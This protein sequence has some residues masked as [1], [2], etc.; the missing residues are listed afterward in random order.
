[1][2][3]LFALHERLTQD[4]QTAISGVELLRGRICVT[5]AGKAWLADHAHYQRVYRRINGRCFRGS[6]PADH[7]LNQRFGLVLEEE[8]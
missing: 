4:S 2:T 6:G 5:D 3:E 1:M 7:A 8:L